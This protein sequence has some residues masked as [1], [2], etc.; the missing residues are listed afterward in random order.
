MSG[1]VIRPPKEY[2]TK[3]QAAQYLNV[4]VRRLEYW[5]LVKKGPAY[6]YGPSGQRGGVLYLKEDLD[7]FMSLYRRIVPSATA[8]A[9]KEAGRVA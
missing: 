8:N 7:S 1:F 3:E 9:M 6:C 5:R 4:P 2:F